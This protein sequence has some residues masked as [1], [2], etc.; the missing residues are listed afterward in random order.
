VRDVARVLAVSTAAVYR[1]ATEGQLH[2]VRVGNAIRVHPDDLRAYA[3][4]LR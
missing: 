4:R 1:L 2:H 3:A